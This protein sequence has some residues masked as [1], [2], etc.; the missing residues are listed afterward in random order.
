MKFWEAMKALEEGCK[1]K[2]EGHKP[3]KY[4]H[5][6]NND[7]CDNENAHISF[8]PA[9]I[10][11]KNW[12]IYE[13]PKVKKEVWQWRKKLSGGKWCVLDILETKEEMTHSGYE[14][15]AGPFEVEE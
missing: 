6:K 13:E 3:G 7:I 15:H 4:F 8:G 5:I 1:V 2:H 12:E 11:F 9:I 10:S 14:I